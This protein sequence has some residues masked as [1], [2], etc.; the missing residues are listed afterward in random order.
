[1]GLVLKLAGWAF[2]VIVSLFLSVCLLYI[3]LVVLT[4][5]PSGR[6]LVGQ[7]LSAVVPGVSLREPSLSLGGNV[8]VERLALTDAEGLWLEASALSLDWS[9]LRL[10]QGDLRVQK[11]EANAISVL[12]Q[13]FSEPSQADEDQSASS[14]SLP[15]SQIEVNQLRIG[16]ILLEASVLGTKAE[17]TVDGHA[18]YSTSPERISGELELTRTDDV[19]GALSGQF[20]FRPMDNVL[21]LK[22]EGFEARGGLAAHLLGIP[23]AP[24]IGFGVDGAGPLS[25][26][27]A[28][29]YVGL[30]AQRVASGEMTV[31]RTES[32]HQVA[33]SFS[34]KLATL[35]PANFAP[36]FEGRTAF[37]ARALLSEA[38]EPQQAEV[39]LESATLDV[40]AKGE[41]LAE[42]GH[43]AV[44]AS[45]STKSSPGAL[46]TLEFDDEPL[47][48]G[49]LQASLTGQGK[50]EA[51]DWQFN[52]EGSS[53]SFGDTGT[54]TF[55]LKA[56]STASNFSL[57]DP[58]V[59]LKVTIE[60]DG[61]RLS[62]PQL[63]QITQKLGVT[64]DGTLTVASSKLQV[65]N[66]EVAGDH[67][68]L[69][70]R[71]STLSATQSKGQG[72]VRFTSLEGLSGVMR[73]PVRGSLASSFEFEADLASNKFSV[74]LDGQSEKVALGLSALDGLLANT[75]RFQLS[76]SGQLE[77][78]DLAASTA[79][80][81][82][83]TV[84]TPTVQLSADGELKNSQ[85]NAALRS[86]LADLSVFDP[87]VRGVADLSAL[88]S[89]DVNAPDFTLDLATDQ[90]V[91]QGT[92]VDALALTAKG[93]ASLSRPQAS[94]SLT[95]TFRGQPFVGDVEVVSTDGKLTVPNLALS[96]AGN[97]IKGQLAA[98]DIASL[99]RGITGDL[100]INAPDL[101]ALSPLVLSEIEGALEASIQIAQS[102]GQT[103][104]ASVK[105]SGSNL[106]LAGNGIE[107][108]HADATINALLSAPQADG[109]IVLQGVDVDQFEITSLDVKAQSTVSAQ[110]GAPATDFQV[111]ATF[112]DNNDG[113]KAVGR[114]SLPQS[115]VDFQLTSLQG[116]YKSIPVTLESPVEIV[117]SDKK[118]S[119]SSV[120]LRVG[121]G[122]LTL[123]GEQSD[124]LK[125]RAQISAFPLSI[126][127]AV[128][129]RLGLSG[130]LNGSV[131]VSGTLDA[132]AA[133]WSLKLADFNNT[134]L[135]QN[136]ILPLQVDSTGTLKS[137]QIEQTTSV[138]N[139][140]GLSLQTKGNLGLRDDQQ[141]VMSIL[142]RLPL[143]IVGAKLIENNL[144]GNGGLD[145]KGQVTGSL[146]APQFNVK[147]TPENMQLTL[148]TS[149]QTFTGFSGSLDATR[150]A[151]KINNLS[152]KFPNEGTVTL[153][154]SLALTA[155]LPADF[156]MIIDNGRLTDGQIATALVDAT[157]S[158]KGPMAAQAS[159]AQIGG[160][161]TI[162]QADIEIPSSFSSGIDP[163]IVRHLNAPKPVAIQARQLSL[164]EGQSSNKKTDQPSA[165]DKAFLNVQIDAPG[166]IFIRGR[167]INAEAGGSLTV[168]GTPANVATTG[169]FSLIRGRMDILSKRL[170]FTRGNVTFTGSLNP[171]LDFA[172][173]TTS[174]STEVTVLVTGPANLPTIGFT[175]SPSLP[176]DEILAQLL[177][178]QSVSSLSPIQLASL[179]GAVATL[180][181]GGTEGPLGSLRNLLGV[182]DI[183]VKFDEKGNPELA[184]GGYLNENIYLGITQDT[185]S[186]ESGAAVDI[187]VT[188]YLKLRG[189]ASSDGDAKAGFYFEQEY[190]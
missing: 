116:S 140:S 95:G 65:R 115:A 179:A 124:E 105:A 107:Q 97:E 20:A 71:D 32:G 30:D 21:E 101:A 120:Q 143:E 46:L 39:S 36:V 89:G 96:V 98:A 64:L 23:E 164:D 184:V 103:T 75:S 88:L 147:A 79:Q 87:R 100:E 29:V 60:S 141:I 142:G 167:G 172:A 139:G 2:K 27:A 6:M 190:D 109:E 183:D 47:S 13:P 37:S 50:L 44:N 61:I 104:Q 121:K 153:N 15:F 155:D 76:G 28:Q 114:L 90:L 77:A 154:G 125:A 148:L 70:L 175:S 126:A 48:V 80:L 67:L 162:K 117:V 173:T 146:S 165:L 158:V 66:L 35:M 11:I 82:R 163:V 94:A 5:V 3:A 43:V 22:L 68:I 180:T 69:E 136:S 145:I 92:P 152:A 8:S 17:L 31:Q 45:V 38:F 57:P 166:K 10:L 150:D 78:A 178:G 161:V 7:G 34:G 157:L 182:S 123:E 62:D 73:A 85:V 74:L 58:L 49:R 113:L 169:G 42:R 25:D 144:G 132:P 53:L 134:D 59:P 131:D 9:P 55:S 72:A 18:A 149:G 19:E 186:G 133:N 108:I 91:M 93:V 99:P 56:K 118:Q 119:V 174:N 83:L 187:D 189:E 24:S 52:A 12:R 177:F 86:N 160:K 51:V 110:L 41:Y 137:W 1:M 129:P 84:S 130:E 16:Q 188:K 181:G 112:P 159:P 81:E 122:L 138:A 185:T 40:Q 4:A 128:V 54:Q 176:Q 156:E 127:N 135:Q 14:F 102:G 26:W 63:S 151:V 171:T 168:S 111:A 33:A 106:R 170:D